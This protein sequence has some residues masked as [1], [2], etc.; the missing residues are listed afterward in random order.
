MEWASVPHSTHVLGSLRELVISYLCM[1]SG[2]GGANSNL[3]PLSQLKSP[4]TVSNFHASPRES[5]HEPC[6]ALL[7]YTA[8]SCTQPYRAIPWT[9]RIHSP[10]FLPLAQSPW[11]P[12]QVWAVRQDHGGREENAAAGWRNTAAAGWRALRTLH[13]NRQAPGLGLKESGG[14]GKNRVTA[15]RWPARPCLPRGRKGPTPQRLASSTARQEALHGW[16]C[17]QDL[18]AARAVPRVA[19]PLALQLVWG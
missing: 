16:T 14:L 11:Q 8:A 9:N 3:N 1:S 19:L 6:I 18:P 4:L 12:E 15:Y 2:G 5:P 7:L 10:G 13:L 17:E